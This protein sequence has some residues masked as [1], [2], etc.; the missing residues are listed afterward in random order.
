MYQT[1]GDY[2]LVAGFWRLACAGVIEA[3]FLIATAG[4]GALPSLG[5][6]LLTQ[7]RQSVVERL[8]GLTPE[9]E[10]VKPMPFH[11]LG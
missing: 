9:V 2:Q 1:A 5:F 6:R 4:L 10:E 3:A 8:L 11:P 7:Q